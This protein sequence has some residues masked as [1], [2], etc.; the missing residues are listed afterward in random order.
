VEVPLRKIPALPAPGAR[1]AAAGEEMTV[2]CLLL[3]GDQAELVP[4]DGQVHDD[5]A[6]WPAAA[7]AEETGLE[8]ADLPG[9]RFRVRVDEAGGL[10]L[11]SG[12]RLLP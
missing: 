2:A 6:R 12:F 8:V 10:V 5:P 9:K 3:F 4:A 1:P 11:F 7:I